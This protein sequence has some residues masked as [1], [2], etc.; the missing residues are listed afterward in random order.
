MCDGLHKLK[1][2]HWWSTQGYMQWRWKVYYQIQF[3]QQH[4]LQFFDAFNFFF[5]WTPVGTSICK[6]YCPALMLNPHIYISSVVTSCKF[7]FG[8]AGDICHFSCEEGYHFVGSS[9]AVCTN[10]GLWSH[11]V[12]VCIAKYIKLQ[13]IGFC[14]F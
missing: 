7:G 3:G 12:P 4:F 1:S 5:R 10:I 13:Y 9:Y 2:I 8:K 11:D 14:L 6:H